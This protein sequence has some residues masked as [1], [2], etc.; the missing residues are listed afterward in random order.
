[1]SA[2]LIAVTGRIIKSDHITRWSNDAVASPRGYTDGIE[3]AGGAAVVLPPVP[4]TDQQAA[5]RLSRFDGLLLTGG[6]DVGPELYGQAP[7]PETYG[8]DAVVDEFEM[9]LLRAALAADMPVL[10]ICRGLQVLNVTLGGSLDQHI[11]DREDV[12]AHGAPGGG[13]GSLH[14]VAVPGGTRLAKAL[15]ADRAQCMSHHHQAVDRVAPG[16]TVTSTA[17]D[18]I[19]EGVEV[20][21]ATWVL[22]VQWHPEETAQADPV[23]QHLFDAFVEEARTWQLRR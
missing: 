9:A 20:D 17:D 13:S 6:A 15:G 14:E 19:V 3:R 16:L 7:R 22:G 18:G 5:A 10:A 12:M 23:Q 8:V 1:V 2:P 11:P 4:L 21:D